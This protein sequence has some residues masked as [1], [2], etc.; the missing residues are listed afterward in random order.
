MKANVAR[1]MEGYGAQATEFLTARGVD[2]NAM[3]AWAKVEHPSDYKAA[4]IGHAGA[5]PDGV[6]NSSYVYLGDD[7]PWSINQDGTTARA[8]SLSPIHQH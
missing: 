1:A 5:T 7:V 3:F 2:P 8:D 4:L 6:H